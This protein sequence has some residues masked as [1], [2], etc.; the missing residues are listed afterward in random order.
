MS[1]TK[2]S[3]KSF[4][5]LCK[6][7][8]LNLHSHLKKSCMATTS[9]NE[10]LEVFKEAKRK[11]RKALNFLTAVPYDSLDYKKSK[12]ENASDFF[13]DFLEKRGCIVYNKPSTR[14]PDC[15]AAGSSG[16]PSTSHPRKQLAEAGMYK[17]H[18]IKSPMLTRFKTYLQ[19]THKEISVEAM[20]DH[21]AKFLYFV[22]PEEITLDFINEFDKTKA[23][24]DELRKQN[25]ENT[26][27]KYLRN[28][29]Q[30]VIFVRDNCPDTVDEEETKTNAKRFLEELN[31]IQQGFHKRRKGM[32]RG[33]APQPITNLECCKILE[34]SKNHIN[35][36]FKK[37][38][39]H[40]I[41]SNNEK[42]LAGSYLIALLI[43][44]HKRKPS[45]PKNLTVKHWLQKK[46]V[47]DREERKFVAVYTGRDIVILDN[48]EE[49]LFTIYFEKIRPTL[50]KAQSTTVEQF[51]LSQSGQGLKNPSGDLMRF[52][53]KFKLPV[54]TYQKAISAYKYWADEMPKDTR[55]LTAAYVN[56][57]TLKHQIVFTDLVEGMKQLVKMEENKEGETSGE[58]VSK[59]PRSSAAQGSDS[60]EG[61]ST[62][63]HSEEEQSS[64]EEESRDEEAVYPRSL[65]FRKLTAIH[66]VA[67]H[68][69]PPTIRE[70]RNVNRE[71]AKFLQ[72]KWLYNQK[73]IRSTDAAEYF[74][75]VPNEK[76]LFKYAKEQGWGTNVPDI[77]QVK[78]AW[79]PHERRHKPNFQDEEIKELVLTQKWKGLIITED[80]GKG[81]RTVK[82]ISAFKRGQVICDYHGELM[83]HQSAEK[84]QKMLTGPSYMY[85]FQHK[86]RKL[87]IN[88]SKAP[89]DCHPDIEST[90]GRL[91]NHKPTNFNLHTKVWS[92]GDGSPTILFYANQDLKPGTEIFFDYGVRKNDFGEGAELDWLDE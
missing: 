74:K 8:Q 12:C 43:L 89:C 52:H 5:K 55:S 67:I 6:T 38:R 22:S 56:Y 71:H 27:Q 13:A 25:T 73:Q 20:V 72:K 82:T 23:Y 58:S 50:D 39:S 83:D 84:L 57:E 24:F 64:D 87:C 17:K 7:F 46:E 49:K 10:Q 11:Q 37:A 53:N 65:L 88:G 68:S 77:K 92:Y 36:I 45:V 85:F 30:F 75:T 44:R 3:V 19:E 63:G 86:G 70:C 33:L 26:I 35:T 9:P 18:D 42:V 66:R 51:F 1:S 90:F 48:E 34:V 14:L 21:V 60:S 76:E 78:S 59:R 41:L 61:S 4:C 47:K 28:V 31:K 69:S 16:E 54:M 15:E 32:K 29:R 2:S 62:E 81:G 40:Q 91:I 79:K 80:I